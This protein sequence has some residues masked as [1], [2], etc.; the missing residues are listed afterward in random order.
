ML[1]HVFVDY[2]VELLTPSVATFLVAYLVKPTVSLNILISGLPLDPP[3]CN[4][5]QVVSSTAVSVSRTTFKFRTIWERSRDSP[6]RNR[7]GDDS[8]SR[9][10]SPSVLS[11]D[12]SVLLLSSDSK[13]WNSASFR[14][15]SSSS[16]SQLACQSTARVHWPSFAWCCLLS[17]WVGN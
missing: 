4:F 7:I 9:G 13:I 17:Y 11:Q 3:V 10:S 12:S 6:T 8:K 5:F 14:D 15:T 16:S 1:Q 2:Q